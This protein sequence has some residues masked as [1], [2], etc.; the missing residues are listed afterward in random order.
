VV[1]RRSEFDARLWQ[2]ASSD[3]VCASDGDGL[4]ALDRT[5]GGW[6]V[7]TVKRTMTARLVCACDGAASAV[8]RLLGLREPAR[9]GHLWV[10][11]TALGGADPGPRASLCDF[12]LRVA[13]AG[14]EGYYWDFPTVMGGVAS[15]SRGIYH[16]NFTPLPDLKRHLGLALHARGIDIGAVRL[17]PFSTRHFVPGTV[18]ALDRVALV[19]EAAGID[20]STGEGIAQSLLMG[21]MAARWIARALRTGDGCL[22]AYADEVRRSRVGRHLLQSAWLARRVYGAGGEPWREF[23]V[24]SGV[25]RA[26]GAAWY[27]GDSLSWPTQ[28]RL[29]MSLGAGLMRGAARTGRA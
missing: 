19:G 20:A 18:L 23:L 1:V 2:R 3:G 11:E 28:V 26:D 29:A 8:R 21:G 5:P 22:A 9:R 10:T 12:D 6:R 17:K 16:A 25:A 13:R 7:T 4:L 27:A 15:V 24:R 14:V